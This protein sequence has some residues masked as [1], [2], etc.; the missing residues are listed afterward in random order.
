MTYRGDVALVTGVGRNIGRAIALGF[1]QR[2]V[3]V[4]INV[5]SNQSEGEA[6]AE[7]VRRL[8]RR[9]VVVVGD[10]ADAAEDERMVRE[11]TDA[12]GPIDYLVD[13]ASP[14]PKELIAD[15]SV[16]SWDA[17][18]RAVLSSTF[19][20]SRLVLPHMAEQQF[21]RVIAIG[22]P[23][24][25]T[26]APQ[27]ADVTA[28]KHGLVGLVK[29]IAAEYG[30]RGVTANL[31]SPGWTDTSRDDLEGAEWRPTPEKLKA[32]LY[33]P[34]LGQPEEIADA[35]LFLASDEASYVTAQQLHVNGGIGLG[36]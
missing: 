10:I 5:R 35:C 25:T 16:E 2:G 17:V 11:A 27:L 31:V 3:S 36:T 32:Q 20:L 22:G 18:I 7:E 33:I 12:L 34:R 6:V 23:I 1:A 15:M 24:T 26:A 9:A 14:R 19:Y 13:N 8:G 28:A 30:D 21:G 4:A 29:T